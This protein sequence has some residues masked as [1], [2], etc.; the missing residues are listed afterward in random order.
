MTTFSDLQDQVPKTPDLGSVYSTSSSPEV[1]V[2]AT[3]THTVAKSA[4]T[5][6][7]NRPPAM[8]RKQT[9]D[10]AVTASSVANDGWQTPRTS[11]ARTISAHS[12]NEYIQAWLPRVMPLDDRTGNISAA[13]R[14]H[15]K[16]PGARNRVDPALLQRVSSS[17]SS[18]NTLSRLPSGSRSRQTTGS[19]HLDRQP[20]TIKENEA[21]WFADTPSRTK[22]RQRQGIPSRM[23]KGHSRK[24]SDGSL[25]SSRATSSPTAASST[26][27]QFREADKIEVGNFL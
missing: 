22:I 15:D 19:S 13:A 14:K 26:L 27:S 10:S 8:Q 12:S 11:A 1:D 6:T 17:D 7:I 4:S 24:G 20:G 18:S 23:L 2:K 16:N 21:T 9:S 5:S 25:I 3:E